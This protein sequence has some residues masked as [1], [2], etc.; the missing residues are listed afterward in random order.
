MDKETEKGAD[1]LDFKEIKARAEVR[2]VLERFGILEHLEE[3]GPELV[4]WCPL[5]R[6]HGKQDSFS[7]NVEKRSFQC[8]ACKA[9]GSVLDFVAKYEDISLRDA[10][11]TVMG[12]LDGGGPESAETEPKSRPYGKAGQGTR[13]PAAR[14]PGAR[15]G[16][17]R[18]RPNEPNEETGGLPF[19][20]WSHA[21]SLVRERMLDPARLVV[22]D[23]DALETF[24]KVTAR[25]SEETA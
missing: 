5:G 21:E 18:E 3:R 13:K 25:P 23:A 7:F 20:T 14:R 17:K 12:I 2:P 4:G 22:I 19:F 24:L 1:W 11:K 16:S 6:E 10:A 8:F 15:R 9:R